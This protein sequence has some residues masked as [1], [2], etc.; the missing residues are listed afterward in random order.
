MRSLPLSRRRVRR[1]RR[2]FTLIEL[3]VAIMIM[4][5]GIL[6]LAST[7]AVVSRLIGDAGQ[8]AL[9]ANVATSRFELLRSTRPCSALTG[10]TAT[11]RGVR[12]AWVVTRPG[13]ADPTLY[14]VVDTVTYTAAGGR[15]PRPQVFQSYLYCQ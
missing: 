15:R 7:A 5:V 11:R 9:L 8:E 12:E 6:G 13:T 1:G 4:V 3:M 14:L 10:G 2:G